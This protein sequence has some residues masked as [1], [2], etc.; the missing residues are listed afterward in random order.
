MTSGCGGVQELPN[1]AIVSSPDGKD[2]GRICKDSGSRPETAVVAGIPFEPAEWRAE[3][4]AFDLKRRLQSSSVPARL[5]LPAWGNKIRGTFP[6]TAR[7]KPSLVPIGG[8]YWWNTPYPIV[9]DDSGPWVSSAFTVA[10]NGQVGNRGDEPTGKLWRAVRVDEDYLRISVGGTDDVG[11]GVEI[12]AKS[13]GS[14]HCT[15]AKNPLHPG[16]R[17][18]E[19]PPGYESYEPVALARGRNQDAVTTYE[20]ATSIPE[21]PLKGSTVVIRIFD[22][23]SNG[24]INVGRIDQT[25]APM[26]KTGTPNTPLWGFADTHTHPTTNLSFGGLQ[27]IHAMWGAPGG[28]IYDYFDPKKKWAIAR[29]IPPCDDPH[30][31]YSAHHGG[32]AAPIMLNFSESHTSESLPDLATPAL[33]DAHTSQGGPSYHDFPHHERGAHFGY[34]ITQIHRAYLG[35]LRLLSAVALQNAGLEWGVGWVNCSADGR[36]TVDT[37]TDMNVINT[38]A[39]DSIRRHG[40]LGAAGIVTVRGAGGR[41]GN[42]GASERGRERWRGE[43]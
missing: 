9:P 24:H 16:V 4:P 36:P 19:A 1:L 32:F 31:G 43:R 40:E 20:L 10:E 30:K 34:H 2:L 28:R 38:T 23:S 8:D 35:G 37:T 18:L 11:V 26:E 17:V 13:G 5:V 39:R 3:G 21:C 22:T 41:R 25:S 15:T 14:L 29:D 12:L 42:E 27:G 7:G 6:A 33:S